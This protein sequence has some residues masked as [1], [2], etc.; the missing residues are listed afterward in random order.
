MINSRKMPTHFDRLPVELLHAIFQF[1]SNCDIIWSFFGISPYLNAMLYDYSWNRLNFQSISKNR[2][3]FICNHLDPERIVCL[4]L[5]DDLTTPGQIQLFFNRFNLQ[6]F[7]NLR[8]LTFLSV[9]NEDINPILSDLPK[10][11]Q[12]TSLITGCRSSTPLSLGQILNQLKYLENL[13]VSH[14]DIF[15]HNV[16]LPL[17]NLKVLNAG[18]CDFLELRRLQVIVPSL[19]SLKIN[20]QAKH[21][22]RLLSYKHIWSSL[23]RLDLTLNGKIY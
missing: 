22:L 12:L 11:K 4:T 1:M 16:T 5:S 10:L 18:I 23:E 20:L 9:T 19:I 15:D 3:D 13:S 8:S 7:T 17:H 21:Q 6:D 2:F 14:G